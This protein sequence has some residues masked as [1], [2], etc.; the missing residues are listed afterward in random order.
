VE[1]NYQAICRAID[2]LTQAKSNKR[3]DLVHNLQLRTEGLKVIMYEKGNEVSVKR[4]PQLPCEEISL[5]GK[6]KVTIDEHFDL[7]MELIP[8]PNEIN[9]NLLDEDQAFLAEEK[10][11]EPLY[12]R[13]AK[14]GE[15]ISPLGREKFTI[16]ISDLMSNKK[17]PSFVRGLYPVL[18]DQKGVLWI[19]GLRMAERGKVDHSTTHAYHIYLKRK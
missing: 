11:L 15:K 12:L 13:L 1:I 18:C 9:F 5:Q 10:I 3:I 19:P 6:R 8:N 7:E 4:Y 2:H 17:I 14:V 16:K